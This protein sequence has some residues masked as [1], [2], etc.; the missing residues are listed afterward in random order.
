[1]PDYKLIFTEIIE[2]S[3]RGCRGVRSGDRRIE[4][5]KPGR[6]S[7]LDMVSEEIR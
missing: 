3:G 4:R 6:S 5:Y 1:M 2:P 7:G